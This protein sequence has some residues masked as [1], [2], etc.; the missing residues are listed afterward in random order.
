VKCDYPNAELS[1]GP[2]R[3]SIGSGVDFVNQRLQV[4]ERA[5]AEGA[6]EAVAAHQFDGPCQQ[7]GAALAPPEVLAQQV[8]EVALCADALARAERLVEQVGGARQERQREVGSAQLLLRE[9]FPVQS[10]RL[11][12]L[13]SD[14]QRN[15]ARLPSLVQ[16]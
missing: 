4:A 10:P 16:S 1:G 9:R 7:C 14:L 12:E 13:T 8:A 6:V 2:Y 3:F 11:R 5:P 15:R